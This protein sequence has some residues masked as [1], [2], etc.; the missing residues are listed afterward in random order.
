MRWSVI[1]AAGLALAI[2]GF[3]GA[4]SPKVAYRVA[5]I[6]A[7]D[8]SEALPAGSVRL[9]SDVAGIL[10]GPLKWKDYYKICERKVEVGAGQ[11]K[12]VTLMNG[13]AVEIDRTVP[14]KRTVTAYQDGR[15]V[16]RTIMPA[17]KCST[18]IG[19]SRDIDSGWFIMVRRE[20]PPG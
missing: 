15:A 1:L 19:G 17:G 7:T 2:C 12:K 11:V 18:L 5:L 8:S 6:R 3:A 4:T 16:A 10:H 13:R 9:T 14:N 20:Q